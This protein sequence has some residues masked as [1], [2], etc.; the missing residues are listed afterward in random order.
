MAATAL[1]LSGIRNTLTVESHQQTYY[2][3]K[4]NISHR[5]EISDPNARPRGLVTR[6]R[7]TAVWSWI[8]VYCYTFWF[9]LWCIRQYHV[10]KTALCYQNK[11]GN[12]QIHHSKAVWEQIPCCGWWLDGLSRWYQSLRRWDTF[13]SKEMTHIVY[14]YLCI[15]VCVCE[16]NACII[17]SFQSSSPPVFTVV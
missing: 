6:K 2:C 17:D 11:P 4:I 12:C 1:F 5:D 10:S 7:N 14:K 9:L 13:H 16:V 15:C 8:R 3:L